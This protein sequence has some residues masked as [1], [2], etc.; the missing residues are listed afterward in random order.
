MRVWVRACMYIYITVLSLRTVV[1]CVSL[2]LFARIC[3]QWSYVNIYKDPSSLFS[4]L[5]TWFIG[6]SSTGSVMRNRRLHGNQAR[7]GLSIPDTLCCCRRW[8]LRL[9]S[10][11]WDRPCGNGCERWHCCYW[12]SSLWRNCSSDDV[13]CCVSGILADIAA[14]AAWD[15]RTHGG[16]CW[17]PGSCCQCRQL[18]RSLTT[19]FLRWFLSFLHRWSFWIQIRYRYRCAD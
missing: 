18:L 16:W 17:S 14:V 3:K 5:P 10:F 12:R 2:G 19:W 11:C 7:V 9:M 15:L 6:R 1:R 13:C 4:M 8:S